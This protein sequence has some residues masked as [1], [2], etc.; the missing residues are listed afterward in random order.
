M[1]RG[2]YLVGIAARLG[3]D[4]DAL[5]AANGMTPASLLVPGQKLVVPQRPGGG[6]T[7]SPSGPALPPTL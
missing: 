3:V 1:V 7:G 4:V 5:L 2:D 6:C